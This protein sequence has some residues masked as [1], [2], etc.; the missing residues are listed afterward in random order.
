MF[1]IPL[2]Y[3]KTRNYNERLKLL[4]KNK[5]HHHHYHST[6]IEYAHNH[7]DDSCNCLPFLILARKDNYLIQI[8]QTVK[9]QDCT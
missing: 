4:I 1:R 5:N 2:L 3:F 9:E 7:K 8:Y 6:A